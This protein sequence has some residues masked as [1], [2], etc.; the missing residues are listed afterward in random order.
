MS[1]YQSYE[2]LEVYRMAFDASMQIMDVTRDLPTEGTILF[3]NHIRRSS[4]L[5]CHHIS[6]AMRQK[7][8]QPVFMHQ[9]TDAKMEAEDIMKW[10]KQ[11]VAKDY[12]NLETGAR[13]FSAYNSVLEKLINLLSQPIPHILQK[14]A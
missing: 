9:L 5:I 14:V 4:R 1:W 3:S 10:I 7:N 12:V 2:T 8:C 6:E 11:A 13:L